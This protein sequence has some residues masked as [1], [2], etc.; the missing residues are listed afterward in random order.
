MESG[1][2]GGPFFGTSCQV[3]SNKIN[4]FNRL[5]TAEPR[6]IQ[7]VGLTGGQNCVFASLRPNCS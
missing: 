5:Q 1:E 6:K 4:N 3:K 2:A 7:P